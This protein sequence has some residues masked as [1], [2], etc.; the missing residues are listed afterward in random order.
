MEG[1]FE[2]LFFGSV[3]LLVMTRGTVEAPLRAKF[4]MFGCAMP[5]PSARTDPSL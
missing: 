4:E 1:M 3:G 2:F 5:V